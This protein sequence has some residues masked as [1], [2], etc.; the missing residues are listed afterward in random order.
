MLESGS[1][2]IPRTQGKLSAFAFGGTCG[3]VCISGA[4]YNV[5][6]ATLTP[7]FPLGMGNDFA[8]DFAEISVKEGRLL[9]MWELKPTEKP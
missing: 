5:S 2:R 4:K 8:A 6:D 1:L 7:N 9:V 3:G